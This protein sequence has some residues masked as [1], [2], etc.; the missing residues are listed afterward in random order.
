MGMETII[1]FKQK[2]LKHMNPDDK[3]I[4]GPYQSLKRMDPNAKCIKRRLPIIETYRPLREINIGALLTR[5]N[6]TDPNEEYIQKH[7]P[8]VG[9]HQSLYFG[10]TMRLLTYDLLCKIQ[11]ISF[12][13]LIL[14]AFPLFGSLVWLIYLYAMVQII[15]PP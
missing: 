13:F 10:Q 11:S 2:T 8:S 1:H 14:R 9:L 15:P 4:K 3:Y 6:K 12:S 7:L 5:W